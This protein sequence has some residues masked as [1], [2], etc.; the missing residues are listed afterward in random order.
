M[1]KLKSEVGASLSFALLLF[2]VCATAGAVILAA[3]TTA[4]GRF[5][6][7]SKMDQRFY[8]VTSAAALLEKEL[9]GKEV[10][11]VRTKV[12]KKE[13]TTSVSP[14]GNSNTVY[15]NTL[16]YSTMINDTDVGEIEKVSNND[17]IPVV[18][19]SE[20]SLFPSAM[21]FLTDQAVL[22][23][24]GDST[25]PVIRC[26]HDKAWERSFSTSSTRWPTENIRTMN[27]VFEFTGMPAGSLGIKGRVVLNANGT[28]NI[29]IMNNEDT[30]NYII[31]MR[32]VPVIQ[33][34]EETTIDYKNSAGMETPIVTLGSDGSYSEY[35]C[36]TTTQTKKATISWVLDSIHG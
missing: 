3:G 32:Y 23:L 12:L 14:E 20:G 6:E 26:N 11:I 27:Y 10:S 17:S 13:E 31:T 22:Y 2:L 1:K 7:L 4:S 29:Y 19:L 16:K 28:M 35:L 25:T 34:D 30:D 18:A 9:S 33:E 5:S 24:F 15:A 21:S 8:S 36:E